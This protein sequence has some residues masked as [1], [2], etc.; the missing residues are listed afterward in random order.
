MVESCGDF[1]RCSLSYQPFAW[2]CLGLCCCC[3]TS[4]YPAL[5]A[6]VTVSC[7]VV[8]AGLY[9]DRCFIYKAEQMSFSIN[10]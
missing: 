3:S 4:L 6:C 2:S 5:C 9:D 10:E 7:R 8:S 1:K